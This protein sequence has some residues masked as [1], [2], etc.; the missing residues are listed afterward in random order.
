[1]INEISAANSDRQLRR[2]ADGY[3]VLGTTP[4]WYADAFDDSH[5][6]ESKGPFGFGS[7]S[8]VSLGLNVSGLMQGRVPSLYVRKAFAVTASQASSTARLELVTRFNDGF[9]AFLNGVEVARRNMGNPGM[10]AYCDQ[11][12]FNTNFPGASA[13]SSIWVPPTRACALARTGSASRLT[14]NP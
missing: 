5:W 6:K 11:T 1:M 3:P 12:A 8:G 13:R 10:Y 9:I 14:T 7:F 4:P 2:T